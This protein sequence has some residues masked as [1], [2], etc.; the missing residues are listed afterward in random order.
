MRGQLNRYGNGWYRMH[1]ITMAG[2][3]GNT[4]RLESN[5]TCENIRIL[6][7]FISKL[8]TSIA[9]KNAM[10]KNSLANVTQPVSQWI[11]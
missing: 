2:T 9:K 6:F 3:G 10:P 5:G 7:I 8:K 1:A 11:W 4:N